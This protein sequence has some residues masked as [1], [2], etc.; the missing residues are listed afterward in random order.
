MA[1]VCL[2]FRRKVS[3]F[4]SCWSVFEKQN[5]LHKIFVIGSVISKTCECVSSKYNVIYPELILYS[6]RSVLNV[7][8]AVWKGRKMDLKSQMRLIWYWFIDFYTF[9]IAEILNAAAWN[10]NFVFRDRKKTSLFMKTA[11][12]WK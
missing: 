8:V 11:D 2:V 1:Q 10:I 4:D 3:Q 5:V 6:L 12:N 7:I 9:S